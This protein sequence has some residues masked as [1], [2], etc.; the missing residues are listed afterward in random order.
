MAD[1][2]TVDLSGAELTS[3]QLVYPPGIRILE[4]GAVVSKVE[5][6]ETV[7]FKGGFSTETIMQGRGGEFRNSRLFDVVRKGLQLLRRIPSNTAGY[8]TA[9]YEIQNA[10]ANISQGI[11]MKASEIMGFI[12]PPDKV[13]FQ[14]FTNTMVNVP[15]SNDSPFGGKVPTNHN[16][17]FNLPPIAELKRMGE[18]RIPSQPP[19]VGV[20]H[21]HELIAHSGM[22]GT[23]ATTQGTIGD[24]VDDHV[25]TVSIPAS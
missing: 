18:V 24:G 22:I 17:I 1:W 12:P 20:A 7:L 4:D 6:G 14:Q 25:H 3:L 11:A 10:I 13:D 9:L 23:T 19:S 2:P 21:Y 16:H 15:S 5:T 8:L